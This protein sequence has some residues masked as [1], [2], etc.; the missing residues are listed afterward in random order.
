MAS[1]H[2]YWGDN[3]EVGEDGVGGDEVDGDEDEVGDGD[4]CTASLAAPCRSTS[5]SVM[6]TFPASVTVASVSGGTMAVAPLSSRIAG[7]STV[8][9][10]AREFR[11]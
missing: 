10:V 5:H 8:R 3:G 11:S 6:W 4:A 7:P 2:K 9:P 1:Q